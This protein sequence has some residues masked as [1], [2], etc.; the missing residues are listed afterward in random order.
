MFLNVNSRKHSGG[1]TI[2]KIIPV[3][4]NVH[5]FDRVFS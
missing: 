5:R 1:E 4:D 3:F 2:E